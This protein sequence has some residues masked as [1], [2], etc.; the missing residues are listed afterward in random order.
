METKTII[1]LGNKVS[2]ELE[3][4][5]TLLESYKYLE[6]YKGLDWLNYLYKDLA[7]DQKHIKSHQRFIVYS[8][9]NIDVVLIIWNSHIECQPHDHPHNGCLLKLMCGNLLEREFLKTNEF[10]LF[11]QYNLLQEGSIYYQEGDYIHSIRNNSNDLSC[12]LHIYAPSNYISKK[13]IYV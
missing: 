6:L 9:K 8:D 13:Y 4:G 7:Q 11:K 12:S 3:N 10:F 5:K 1:E 2:R